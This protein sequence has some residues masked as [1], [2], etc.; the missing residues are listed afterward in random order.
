MKRSIIVVVVVV[1]IGSSSSGGGDGVSGC[2]V[3]F[4]VATTCLY[5]THR[6]VDDLATTTTITTGAAIYYH[7]YNWV[8]LSVADDQLFA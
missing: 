2:V 1:V 6:S 7:Y 8:L 4:D 3:G 5:H